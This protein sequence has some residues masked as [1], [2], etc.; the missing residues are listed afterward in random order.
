MHHTHT[1][2]ASSL[3]L[4]LLR[5]ATKRTNDPW[6]SLLFGQRVNIELLRAQ[7]KC[8]VILM[9][10]TSRVVFF[11]Q[12][13]TLAY[14]HSK[15]IARI[16]CEEICPKKMSAAYQHNRTTIFKQ[17][18]IIFLF[19]LKFT[20]LDTMLWP[21]LQ[22]SILSRRKR[23]PPFRSKDANRIDLHKMWYTAEGTSRLPKLW[24]SLWQGKGV[25]YLF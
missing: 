21:L 16:N 7:G 25:A 3:Y 12:L 20:I 22:L 2:G 4:I 10:A 11:L 9:S 15:G 1:F 14:L 8:N 19:L 17:I 23:G 18:L 6:I 13:F 24:C 5:T